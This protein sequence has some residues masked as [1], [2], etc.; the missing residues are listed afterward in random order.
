MARLRDLA[1]DA[2][3]VAPNPDLPDPVVATAWVFKQ[4]CRSVDPAALER[5]IDERAGKGPEG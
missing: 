1:S 3:V 5:F 4:R 2:V